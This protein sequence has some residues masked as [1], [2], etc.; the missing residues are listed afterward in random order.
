M[1]RVNYWESTPTGGWNLDARLLVDCV[2]VR[3]ALEWADGNARGRKFELLA[4]TDDSGVE[5]DVLVLLLG[6]DPN[7]GANDAEPEW[8]MRATA[9]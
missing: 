6:S 8:E 4:T 3:D 5:T 2:D 9:N 1:Y 7:Q